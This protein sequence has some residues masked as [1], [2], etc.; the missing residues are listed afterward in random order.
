MNSSMVLL[1]VSGDFMVKLPKSGIAA[2]GLVVFIQHCDCLVN[3]AALRVRA[4]IE[5]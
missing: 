4:K 1:H 2:R 3:L 5:T